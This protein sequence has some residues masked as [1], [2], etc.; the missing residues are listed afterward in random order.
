[1]I[2]DT[3]RPQIKKVFVIVDQS[4]VLMIIGETLK[5]QGFETLLTGDGES[6]IEMA[7]R[8]RPDLI[9]CDVNMPNLDGYETLTRLRQDEATATT[10]FI[11][12]S[13]AVERPS[14]RLGMEA[15]I[16]RQTERK[17]DELRGNITIVL[18]HELRTPLNG[19]M[20]LSTMLMEDYATMPSAEILESAGFIILAKTFSSTPRSK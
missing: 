20:G 9:I 19:I 14:V 12:L 7:C 4:E 3:L 16:A 15:V 17:L 8:E 2:T 18:P 5:Y 11:F 6:G 10:P 1:M 13:G